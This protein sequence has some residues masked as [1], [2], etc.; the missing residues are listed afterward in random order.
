MKERALVAAIV[1]TLYLGAPG[2]LWHKKHAPPQAAQT[3]RPTAPKRAAA[4]KAARSTAK[5]AAPPHRRA[6]RPAPHAQAAQPPSAP[7]GP[8]APPA[9]PEPLGQMLTEQERA[10]LNRA[11][12]QSLS[13]TRQSLSEISERSLSPDQAETVNLVRAFISQAERARSTDLNTAAQLARR[14]ELLARS[15]VAGR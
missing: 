7:V 15:L 11:L 3:P 13:S 12:D 6:S 10:D 1:S 9:S 8:P 5:G 4:R 14:A 2:C